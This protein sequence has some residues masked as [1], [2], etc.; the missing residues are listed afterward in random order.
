MAFCADHPDD[1]GCANARAR[2]AGD[3]ADDGRVT[4]RDERIKATV[5]AAP[6][7]GDGFRGDGLAEVRVPVQV[8]V[9]GEDTVVRD[10]A[11]VGTLLPGTSELHLVPHAGHSAFLAPC[12]E[13]LV[14]MAAPICTDP[15]GFDRAA[16][17]RAFQRVVIA[18]LQEK[19]GA[20]R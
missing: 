11:L 12:S 5:V 6:A 18:F 9:A 15:P 13:A 2:A 16:F 7:L 19:L 1:W 4:G 17:L 3:D 8:W 14:R 20:G 10:A